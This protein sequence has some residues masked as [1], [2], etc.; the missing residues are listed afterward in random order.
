LHRA[1]FL[2]GIGCFIWAIVLFAI[3]DLPTIKFLTNLY[4]EAKTNETE[5]VASQSPNKINKIEVIQ[6]GSSVGFGDATILSRYKHYEMKSH[7]NNND[8]K[9]IHPSTDISIIWKNDEE[10]TIT[11]DGEQQIPE[12][13][14]FK[15]PNSKESNSSP[16]TVAL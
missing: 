3:I 10:A 11:L 5:L 14:E 7:I 4:K 15:V 2:S 8:G 13:I 16:F 12:I 9:D 1:K 6:K